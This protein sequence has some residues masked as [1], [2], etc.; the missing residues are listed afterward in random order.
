MR[1]YLLFACCL[2][3]TNLAEGQGPT[4]A[5][6]RSLLSNTVQFAQD[7]NVFFNEDALS[8]IGAGV[9]AHASQIVQQPELYPI[10]EERLRQIV[11]EIAR[12]SNAAPAPGSNIGPSPFDN[13]SLRNDM[14]HR[15]P[16]TGNIGGGDEDEDTGGESPSR[17]RRTVVSGSDV[18]VFLTSFCPLWPVC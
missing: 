9:A 15:P 1:G 2:V 6:Y 5:I 10:A 17:S 4:T 3:S 16:I 14:P 8:Q 13:P 12:R 11:I 7:N 18:Y